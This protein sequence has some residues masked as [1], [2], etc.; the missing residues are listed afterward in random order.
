MSVRATETLVEGMYW[1]DESADLYPVIESEGHHG[2]TH[3]GYRLFLLVLVAIG[4]AWVLYWDGVQAAG[5][6]EG[7][8]DCVKAAR[9]AGERTR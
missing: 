4:S 9:Y 1:C 6:A 3:V 8:K 7:D 2:L 5:C